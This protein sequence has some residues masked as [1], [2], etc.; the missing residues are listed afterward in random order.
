MNSQ[1]SSR[2]NLECGDDCQ[3]Q[4]GAIVGL[5][6]APGAGPVRLGKGARIRAG[7]I[8]YADV[9]VGEDF[10]TGHHVLVREKT[11][12]GDH[13]VIGTNTVID[14]TVTIGSFVKIE[15]NCYIPTHTTIGDRVFFGP[16]VT[17]T[18][19]RYPLKL[20]DQYIPEGPVIEDGVTLG[21][22]VVVL[23]GVRIG[24]DSFVAAGA[25]VT[26]DVP[27]H[28]LVRGVPGRAVPAPEKLRERNL[29]LSWRKHL[30][31]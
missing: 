26:S 31:K 4:E 9:V 1:V 14:G 15:S 3:I 11:I 13:V 25:V 7:A 2:A 29:A 22:G 28:S 19:D 17:L 20:R 16:G 27:P 12:V 23:P 10:Q 5:M 21:G 30:A 8:L 24:H 18:N 6:Y